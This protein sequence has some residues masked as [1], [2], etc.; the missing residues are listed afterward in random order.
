MT[1]KGGR[2]DN[3]RGRGEQLHLGNGV[4]LRAGGVAV[5]VEVDQQIATVCLDGYESSAINLLDPGQLEFEYMQQMTCALDSFK[6]CGEAIRALHLGGCACALPWAWLTQRPG[7][8]HSVVE[9]NE[10]LAAAMRRVFDL[11]RSPSLR[12]RI[13]D[14]G[15]VI[16]QIREDAYDVVVRDVFNGPTTPNTVR[17]GEFFAQCQR[18]LRDGGL[19]LVNCGHGSGL[20]AREEVAAALS[21]FEQVWLIGEGKVLAHGRRGNLVMVA[22]DCSDWQRP[23]AELN[24]QLRRLAVSVR[25]LPTSKTRRWVG[26][27]VSLA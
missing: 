6:P 27:A 22:S 12:I 4:E 3:R 1:K 25:L 8:E 18:I 19:A 20:D 21:V 17:T 15:Q 26:A 23:Y 13:G 7:S 14:A 24:R 11:P 5:Q 9:L 10:E 2:V 16:H